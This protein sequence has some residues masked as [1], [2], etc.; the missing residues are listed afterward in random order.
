MCM[1]RSA[2]QDGGLP[3]FVAIR[4]NNLCAVKLLLAADANVDQPDAVCYM[5]H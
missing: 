2:L 3:L 1:I 5:G 4:R